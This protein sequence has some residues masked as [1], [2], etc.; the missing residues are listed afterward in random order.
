MKEILSFRNFSSF[1]LRTPLFSYTFID[2]IISRQNISEN[3]LKI[4]CSN[5]VIQEAIF[6]A[7]PDLYSEFK[8]WLDNEVVDKTDDKKSNKNAKNIQYTLLKYLLRMSSRCTP[9]GLFAG[10]SLGDF[11]KETKIEFPKLSGYQRHTRLDMNYLCALAQDLATL[12]ELKE[13]IKYY[14]NS[15]IYQSGNQLRYVEY[16]YKNTGRFHYI[17]AVDHSKYLEKILET[18]SNGAY[19]NELARSIIDD[20]ISLEEA[21][22]FIAEII[23]SQLLVSELEPAITGDEFLGQILLILKKL[24]KTTHIQ[25]VLSQ[26]GDQ[27]AQIDY[28]KIG[29]NISI[30]YEIAEKLKSLNTKYELKYLFQTDMVKSTIHCTLSKNIA[31]DILMGI[32]VL[33]KLTLP[34]VGNNLT[35]FKDAFRERYEDREMTL[36]HVLDK[37]VGIGYLQNQNSGDISP[38]VDDLA[39]PQ[40]SAISSDIKWNHIQSFIFQKYTEAISDH[41]YEVEFTDK[42]LEGFWINWDDLPPTIS[43]MVNVFD[44]GRIHITNVGGSSSANLLGR[45]CH[46]DPKTH[47]YVKEITSKEK[48]LNPD[49]IFAE[50]IHLPDSR[51]GNVLLRPV[52]RDYEIPYLSKPA[53]ES[54]FQI[55]LQDLLVSVKENR[56]ILRSKRLNKE[57][58]PRLSSAHNY[59]FNALPAYQFLCDMQ[60]QNLRNSIGFNWGALSNEYPFL[61]RVKFKNL[62]FSLATWNLKKDDIKEIVSAK[63]DKVLLIEVEKL[64]MAK[65]IPA[66]VLLEDG[67]NEL[68]INL[69]NLLC[70]KT[71]ISMVKNRL[72][73]KLTEYLFKADKGIV[74]SKEEIFTNQFVISFYKTKTELQSHG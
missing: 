14:P 8:K 57:I 26:I 70:V 15:S 24:D 13:Q 45:F 64:R 19:I 33:N 68:L 48:E 28:N 7:S 56:I 37:E 53:V 2:A 4:L 73:F 6:L 3:E 34:P 66:L 50:V 58:I 25:N 59:T 52:L 46:A 47:N 32:E 35:L 27:L 63:E 74:R 44:D 49:F 38:L 40:R 62:I 36:L 29:T 54:S 18:A 39:L 60:T 21:K 61:P 1:V 11:D 41:K 65:K 9:F 12:P 23:E 55:R 22:N 43:S 31:K 16:H 51:L 67:D 5:P 71:L 20:D 72:L 17:V 69:E 10:F 42:D 30:Y